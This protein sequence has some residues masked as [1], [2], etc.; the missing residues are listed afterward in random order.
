MTVSRSRGDNLSPHTRPKLRKRRRHVLFAAAAAAAFAS[1]A[2]VAGSAAAAPQYGVQVLYQLSAGGGLIGSDPTAASNQVVGWINSNGS[3]HA[4][5]WPAAGTGSVR[6]AVELPRPS[7]LTG[8]NAWASS[9]SLV[10]GYG[11]AINSY[12]HA[13]LWNGGGVIDL[14]PG[15]LPGFTNTYAA[16]V[17]GGEEVGYGNYG[18]RIHAIL[19]HGSADGAVDLTPT[20]LPGTIVG[21][22]AHGTDGTYEVGNATGIGGSPFPHAVMWAGSANTAVDLNPTNLPYIASSGAAAVGGGQEV[23][24]GSGSAAGSLNHPLL[25]NGTSPNAIDLTPTNLSGFTTGLAAVATNGRD[26][27]GSGYSDVTY[28]YQALLWFGSGSSTVNLGALLPSSYTNS[29]ADA[30]DDAGNVFGVAEDAS[31]AYYAVEFSPVPEP[32]SLL[33][34][35]LS[36]GAMLTRRRKPLGRRATKT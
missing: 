18:S 11:S 14:E 36:A 26:Q 12:N 24:T 23:G 16:A 19:W 8:A 10:V 6:G 35:G 7:G 30:I 1:C 15:N 28:H 32:G 31:G 3:N 9:G 33:L 27:V 21:S 13:L 22:E 5:V 17:A 2:A 25:W 4:V 29:F 20:N 34:L